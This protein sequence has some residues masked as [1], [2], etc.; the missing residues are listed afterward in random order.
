MVEA[1]AHVT[2]IRE[3]VRSDNE[4]NVTSTQPQKHAGAATD[5]K[6]RYSTYFLSS[7]QASMLNVGA[8]KAFLLL[9]NPI[10]LHLVCS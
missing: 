1:K 8:Y 7:A 6:P 5:L 4:G 2:G 9:T 10:K 3:R